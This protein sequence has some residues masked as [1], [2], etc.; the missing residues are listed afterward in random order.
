MVAEIATAEAA[1]AGSDDCRDVG[2][3][4]LRCPRRDNDRLGSPGADGSISRTGIPALSSYCFLPR[5]KH[6]HSH[7]NP[8]GGGGVSSLGGGFPPR[9]T[10]GSTDGPDV[11][12]LAAYHRIGVSSPTAAGD[13]TG[14]AVHAQTHLEANEGFHAKVPILLRDGRPEALLV[15]LRNLALLFQVPKDQF[16]YQLIANL[17]GEAL[18][19]NNLHLAGRDTAARLDQ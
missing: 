6:A 15:R 14:L 19:W 5:R 7:W 11:G 16:N 2:V 3:N 9:G 18:T 10:C 17:F 1:P 12:S 4:C 13:V 8:D